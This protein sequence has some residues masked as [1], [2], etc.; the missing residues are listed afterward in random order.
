MLFAINVFLKTKFTNWLFWIFQCTTDLKFCFSV[1]KIKIK[2]VILY[3]MYQ[4]C[5]KYWLKQIQFKYDFFFNNVKLIV[6]SYYINI[7]F[8]CIEEFINVSISVGTQMLISFLWNMSMIYNLISV[9]I[10]IY[11]YYI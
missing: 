9:Y 6:I 8:G 11:F 3:N 2:N 5:Q 4:K 7:L 1:L 10:L